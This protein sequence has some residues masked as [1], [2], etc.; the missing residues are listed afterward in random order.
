MRVEIRAPTEIEAK[1]EGVDK[2]K[3][4]VS[5]TPHF[6]DKIASTTTALLKVE[7]AKGKLLWSGLIMINPKNG[8]PSLRQRQKAIVPP[9]DA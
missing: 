9:A 7:N 4:A 5:L 1:V 3:G 6:Y 2:D 8:K